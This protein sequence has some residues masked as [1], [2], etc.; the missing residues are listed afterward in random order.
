MLNLPRASGMLRPALLHMLDTVASVQTICDPVCEKGPY[1][2]S[3]CTYLVT[4]NFT[5]E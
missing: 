4:H 3:D 1:S 5:C 2:L